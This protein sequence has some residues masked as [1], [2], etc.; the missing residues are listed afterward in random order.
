[1]DALTFL[2]IGTAIAATVICATTDLW[3][4]RIYNVV[5]VPLLAV[6]LL[7]HVLAG[8]TPALAFSGL[9]ALTGFALL[10]PLYIAG[11]MGAGDVKLMTGLGACLLPAATL[12]LVLAS[13][14]LAGGYALAL[15]VRGRIAHVRLRFSRGER[16]ED[17]CNQ[18]GR[19]RQL[20]PFGAV[21]AAGLAVSLAWSHWFS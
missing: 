12:Q 10:I 15:M 3:R 9:G 13:C 18:S 14:L 17:V 2:P 19:R 8:G 7:S 5:T 11:G 4:M 1:M 16:L 20:I 21:T 6:G